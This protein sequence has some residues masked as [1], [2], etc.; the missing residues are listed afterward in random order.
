MNEIPTAL[1][2][3]HRAQADALIDTIVQST[4]EWLDFLDYKGYSEATEEDIVIGLN[5]DH[6][7][8]LTTLR[9]GLY[10]EYTRT[11]NEVLD[12]LYESVDN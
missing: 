7:D 1:I 12:R 2:T 6:E 9:A 10:S 11:I 4:K 8:I 5:Y 3:E